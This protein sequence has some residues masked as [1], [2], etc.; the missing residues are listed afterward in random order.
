MSSAAQIAA[1][2]RNAAHCTG[3]RT[4]AGKEVSKFNACRHGLSSA[5]VVLSNEDRAA[6]EDLK[7][8]LIAEHKP[9][10]S[11]EQLFVSQLAE[12]W[13]RCLRARRVESEYLGSLVAA[14]PAKGDATIANAVT[15]EKDN[16]FAKLQRYVNAADRAFKSVLAQL[17]QTQ[18]ARR[19]N[20]QQQREE[21]QQQRV[22]EILRARAAARNGFVSQQSQPAQKT[23]PPPVAANPPT[24][25]LDRSRLKKSAA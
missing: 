5:Q 3:P 23:P 9:V 18:Q 22:N 8:T 2:R 6:F 15:A 14:D 7:T 24:A 13:W 11:L 17:R 10:G 1:N 12:T 21:E 4:E 19:E 20:Q 16:A 25:S